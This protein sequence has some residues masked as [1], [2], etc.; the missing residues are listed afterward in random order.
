VLFVGSLESGHLLLERTGRDASATGPST[1]R[2]DPSHPSH[3]ACSSTVETAGR[4]RRICRLAVSA[5][6]G[7]AAVEEGRVVD[8][9]LPPSVVPVL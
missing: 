3:T 1:A 8:V 5:E 4:P 7:V 2:A 9:G 6:A